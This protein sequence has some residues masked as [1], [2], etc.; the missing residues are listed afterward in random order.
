MVIRT[1]AVADSHGQNVRKVLERVKSGE[2]PMD[3][4]VSLTSISSASMN[5]DKETGAIVPGASCA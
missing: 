1:D 3:A 4:I 5:V 2:K